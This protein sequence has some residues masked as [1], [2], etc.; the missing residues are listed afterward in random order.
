M[1]SVFLFVFFILNCFQKGIINHFGSSFFMQPLPSRLARYHG[2]SSGSQP[3]LIFRRSL[4]NEESRF[5]VI[6]ETYIRKPQRGWKVL[7]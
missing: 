7:G 2:V 3:H 5:G 4:D 6:G 1:D